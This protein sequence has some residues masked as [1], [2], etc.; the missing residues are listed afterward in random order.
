[1]VVLCGVAKMNDR[2]MYYYGGGPAW[3]CI[4]ELYRLHRNGKLGLIIVWN[5]K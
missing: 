3:R 5:I 2:V 1:M 4:C